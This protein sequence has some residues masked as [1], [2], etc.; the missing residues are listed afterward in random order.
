METLL[1]YLEELLAEDD[2]DFLAQLS[3]RLDQFI[4]RRSLAY[5]PC[6]KRCGL[7][8]A[9]DRSSS[10]NM[11]PSWYH[12]QFGY[13]TQVLTFRFPEKNRSPPIGPPY[14]VA[15][16]GRTG[17]CPALGLSTGPESSGA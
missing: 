10:R 17:R 5:P 11:I 9:S 15:A 12:R 16:V 1:V 14:S 7:G 2:R 13:R 3:D 8:S 6:R 4:V